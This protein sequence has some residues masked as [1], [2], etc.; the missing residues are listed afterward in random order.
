MI[1]SNRDIIKEI[2]GGG[3]RFDPMIE[4]DQISTSSIDLRI[5]NVFTVP[6]PPLRGASITIDSGESSPEDVFARYAE[7]EVVPD[8]GKF[9]LKPGA[10]VL[11]Y[12]LER[13]WL[14]NYLAARIE[15]RS[16]MARFG[17]SI[18]QTAPTVH[19]NFDGQLR[20]EISNV[21]P[22]TVLIEPGMRFC[23]LI[24]EKLSSPADPTDESRWQHQSSGDS[25][26]ERLG[27]L[28]RGGGGR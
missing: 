5:A 15:G 28:G 2:K 13:V 12:T 7:E 6:F 25:G 1:L 23:Q 10:F 17:V 24:V 16:S 19:A 9:E 21:G 14:P 18:H 3:L 22:Y 11:G 27:R 26:P 8:E 4:P 20:L